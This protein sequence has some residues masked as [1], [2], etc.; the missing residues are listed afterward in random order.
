MLAAGGGPARAQEEEVVDKA[1]RADP[2]EVIK[3]ILDGGR[4]RQ[5]G[6]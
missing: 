5:R 1:G 6:K 2:V 3:M 4:R